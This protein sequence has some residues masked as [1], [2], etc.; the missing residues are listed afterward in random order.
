[1]NTRLLIASSVR[2]LT[3]YKLRS[4]FMSLGIVIGV[5][6]L[7]V[8]RSF[9]SSAEQD[10]LDKM[11]RMFSASSMTLMNS[12]G[13]SRAGVR[14]PGRMTLEDIEAL[15]EQFD[16][17]VDWSS[18]VYGADHEVVYQGLN[19]NLRVIGKSDRAE[20]VSGRGVMEGEFL[21]AADIQSASRVA[22]IGHK[23]AESL[24]K[25]EEPLGKLIQI[26]GKPYRVKGILEPHG[27]D[28]HGMDLDDEV[29]VPVT[30]M[31]RRLLNVEVITSARLTISSVDAVEGMID[32]VADFLRARH[33]L[34]D[35]EPDDF[36]IYTPTQVQSLVKKANRVLT[37]FLPATA[38]IALLVAAIV[39]AN[40][41]LIGVRER[42]GEI[43]LRKAVGATNRQ[44]G[45]QFL[46][47]SLAIAVLSG[48]LGVA[49]GAGSLMV[50]ARTTSPET[51]LSIDSILIGLV[52]AL[53]VGVLAGYLP[54]RKAAQ[55]EPVE[56]LQ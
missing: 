10:M 17:I 14:N 26:S 40:I 19:R 41:M 44:I 43:G 22:L 25:G 12:G 46:L 6:A 15:G 53:V 35:S 27:I 32:P 50:V 56:A 48:G 33:R 28:P 45:V 20:F 21:T 36:T 8:M 11:E 55:Q 5:A 42:I 23:T 51:Q 38:G 37:V 4:F 52:A 13:M 24:F 2:V 1:M 3:R 31:M 49:L 18:S 9:G 7:V 30:T 39:I 16:A 47:E 29:H 54:A 34:A